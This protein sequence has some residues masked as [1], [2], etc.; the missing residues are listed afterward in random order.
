M[1]ASRLSLRISPMGT[2]GSSLRSSRLALCVGMIAHLLAAT[3]FSQEA[4]RWLDKDSNA[5]LAIDV[6]AAY[7]SPIAKENQWAKKA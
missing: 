3:A 1:K 4:V 7:R 5:V 2:L 6:A